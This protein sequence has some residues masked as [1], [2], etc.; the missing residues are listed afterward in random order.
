MRTVV[1]GSFPWHRRLGPAGLWVLGFSGSWQHSLGAVPGLTR[2]RGARRP[3]L[4]VVVAVQCAGPP[5]RC[6]GCA[7]LVGLTPPR[8]GVRQCGGLRLVVAFLLRSCMGAPR[9]K[10]SV[11]GTAPFA[12]GQPASSCSWSWCWGQAGPGCTAW[13][14]QSC[15]AFLA[16]QGC[17]LSEQLTG[18]VRWMRSGHPR[19]RS[20]YTMGAWLE[21][22]SH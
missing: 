4:W 9:A 7:R 17:R 14:V 20:A 10:G 5:W 1:G 19:D 11:T 3:S 8:L 16:F 13:C 22:P 21:L 15:I 12:P 6:S 2:T 18:V